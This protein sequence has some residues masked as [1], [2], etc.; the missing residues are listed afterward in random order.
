MTYFLRVF[1]LRNKRGNIS[2]FMYSNIYGFLKKEIFTYFWCYINE[3]DKNW[4]SQKEYIH[5]LISISCLQVD[6]EHFVFCHTCIYHK[7][8]PGETIWLRGKSELVTMCAF[9]ASRRR[10]F[11]CLSAWVLRSLRKIFSKRNEL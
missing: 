1:C 11:R 2:I 9:Y 5:P 7:C 6:Y 4:S 10:F 8:S 3:T